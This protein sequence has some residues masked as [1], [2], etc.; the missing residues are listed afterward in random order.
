MKKDS[1]IEDMGFQKMGAKNTIIAYLKIV[2]VFPLVMM[3]N[4]TKFLFNPKRSVVRNFKMAIIFPIIEFF[5]GKATSEKIL[6]DYTNIHEA[7]LKKEVFQSENIKLNFEAH[8]SILLNS[9]IATLASI[10][11]LVVMY[12][13][14]FEVIDLFQILFYSLAFVTVGIT[15][16]LGFILTALKVILTIALF[17]VEINLIR[18]IF[19][20]ETQ[21]IRD[22]IDETIFYADVKNEEI[23]GKEHSEKVKNAMYEAYISEKAEIQFLST[24]LMDEYITHEQ[25]KITAK[26]GDE[27]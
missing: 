24:D 25:K 16:V 12:E 10:F 6:T 8:K 2:V 17:A 3:W 15:A 5:T 19:I 20:T 21:E 9:K 7:I 14:A 1:Y 22:Y 27:K 4:I 18:A 13:M 11:I 23:F 26:I